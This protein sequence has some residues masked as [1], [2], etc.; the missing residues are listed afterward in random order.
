MSEFSSQKLLKMS[1]ERAQSPYKQ[2]QLDV[3]N[4][5]DQNVFSIYLVNPNSIPANEIFCFSDG[6]LAKQHIRGSLRAA[7]HTGL[8]NPQVYFNVS[9]KKK[10]IYSVFLDSIKCIFFRLI[11]NRNR[12]STFPL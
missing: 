11:R 10:G 7:I 6:N 3:I 1:K 9:K 8:N 5:L 12:A 2:A 4:Y